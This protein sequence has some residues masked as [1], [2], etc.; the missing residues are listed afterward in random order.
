MEKAWLALAA[1]GAL[2]LLPI[3]HRIYDAKLLILTIPACAMLW[4]DGGMMGRLALGVNSAAIVLTGD[5][6]WAFL[7]SMIGRMHLSTT[8]RSGQILTA[9]VAFPAPAILLVTGVFYLW[10]YVSNDLTKGGLLQEGSPTAAQIVS[11][12]LDFPANIKAPFIRTYSSL[13]NIL[14]PKKA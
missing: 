2:S 4:A 11:E 3:Y 7:F 5:L 8:G 1:I 9:M 6:P 10:I 12:P 13:L 14:D